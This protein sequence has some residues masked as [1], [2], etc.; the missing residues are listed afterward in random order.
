M[1]YLKFDGNDQVY[2]RNRLR[3]DHNIRTA[4]P[5]I[6]PDCE[7]LIKTGRLT[8]IKQVAAYAP[9]T[10]DAF[11]PK[12]VREKREKRFK[13]G[14]WI[15]VL[16]L[17]LA[18]AGAGMK[19]SKVEPKIAAVFISAKL[20][21]KPIQGWLGFT[22][23]NEGDEV[24]AV[25][26][27]KAEHDEVYAILRPQDHIISIMPTCQ[28]GHK[29]GKKT[30]IKSFY[31]LLVFIF[32]LCL[33][34]SS[35][36]ARDLV[37]LAGFTAFGMIICGCVG[38][39]AALSVYKDV[40]KGAYHFAERIFATLGWKNPEK[41]D[42]Y[43]INKNIIKTLQQQNQYSEWKLSEKGLRPSPLYSR[44]SVDGFFY[45]DENL[46]KDNYLTNK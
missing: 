2:D 31:G 29:A 8:D 21:D 45:Y 33:F 10:L 1:C 4:L 6:E 19:R 38:V 13:Q 39:L 22:K 40:K 37:Q 34:V 23:F 5:I 27:P 41:I 16:N 36:M 18:S 3:I 30:A 42:L 15:N 35:L 32:L 24:K 43:Y 11:I 9:I 20:D 28:Q 12:D 14:A 44:S 7:L 46:D 17:G 25:V 26:S